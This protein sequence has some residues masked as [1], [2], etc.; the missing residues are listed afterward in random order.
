[1]FKIYYFE[2]KV[3]HYISEYFETK[4][5]AKDWIIWQEECNWVTPRYH[6]EKV[7]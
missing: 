4:Q 1:M 5:I 2:G 3:K 6:I 7:W